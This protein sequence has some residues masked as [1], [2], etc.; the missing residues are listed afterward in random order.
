MKRAVPR[1]TVLALIC[2]A[3]FAGCGLLVLVGTRR[4]QILGW[5]VAIAIFAVA[6]GGNVP[7]SRAAGRPEPKVL[8]ESPPDLDAWQREREHRERDAAASGRGDRPSG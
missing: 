7:W 4:E 2:V 5:I 3:L 8:D 6:L 1:V